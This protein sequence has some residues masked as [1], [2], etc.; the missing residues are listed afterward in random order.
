M[1]SHPNC[2]SPRLD[3]TNTAQLPKRI[4]D[5]GCEDIP[6]RLCEV[7]SLSV[8]EISYVALSHCWG[9][10]QPYT[11]EKTS[12]DDR[13]KGMPWDDIPKTFQDAIITTRSLRLRY[14]WIDSLCIVKD[15]LNDWAEESSKMS[16]VYEN[17]TL[18]I[19]AA[20]A[21]DDTEGFLHPRPNLGTGIS[22]IGR[23]HDTYKI[24]RDIHNDLAT[25]GPL[26]HRG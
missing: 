16:H 1:Q 14:I 15:D 4:I 23:L 26:I 22:A 24:R 10:I 5:V 9:S 20:A 11:T 17:A 21:K 6:P 12:I 3:R 7:G 18:T 25:T 13:M 19:A 2:S 8:P